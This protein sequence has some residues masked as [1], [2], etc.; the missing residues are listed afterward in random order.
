MPFG[1][2]Q[3]IVIKGSDKSYA[4]KKFLMTGFPKFIWL[5]IVWSFQLKMI[6]VFQNIC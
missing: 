1:D 5:S 3:N 6:N 2:A 4:T